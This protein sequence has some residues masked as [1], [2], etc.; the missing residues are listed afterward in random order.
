MVL[1]GRVTLPPILSHDG[2]PAQGDVT[3]L[4]A[5]DDFKGSLTA[6]AAAAAMRLGVEDALPLARVTELPLADGGDGSVDAAVRAGYQPHSVTVRGP[7]GAPVDSV[8]ALHQGRAIVEVANTCGLLLLPGGRLEPL[9]S[10][11]AGLGDAVLAA[12]TLGATEVVVC[13]GG[14]ASTDGGA[15]LLQ[16]LGAVLTGAGGE[17]VTA[18]GGSLAS[19]A[20][21]DLDGLDP[22]V[23]AAR[24]VAATDVDSP[25]TGER[26]AAAVFA[27]QKGADAGTVVRLDAALAAWGR[28][29]ARTTGRDVTEAPGAGA[30]GGTGAALLAAL[31]AERVSG[32]AY[33]QDLTG[34]PHALAGSDLV[35]TGEG[36][37]DAQSALGKGAM[38]VAVR[39]QAM[40]VACVMVCGAIDVG[41]QD[42]ERVG[43][44]STAT[45]MGLA[46]DSDDAMRRAGDLLRQATR[47]AVL[48][49]VTAPGGAAPR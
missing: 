46:G 13:L 16:A 3:V 12:L 5:P 49:A 17:P 29:L 9:A 39:A 42:L 2:R 28:V 32:A 30:A 15:G 43:V 45:I 14:S 26:G 48:R 38:S 10:S 27:P 19:I 34:L 33:L 41:T 21:L 22:R 8:I 7:T 36:R 23:R 44:Q 40:G 18:T 35:V 24:F 47:E 4:V 11:T 37:L 6:G 20:T 25:L 31:S 1:A